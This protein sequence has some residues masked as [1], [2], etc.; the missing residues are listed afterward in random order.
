MNTSFWKK[1]S[2]KNKK[3]VDVKIVIWL[4]CKM[5]TESTDTPTYTPWRYCICMFFCEMKK[6]N[7][8]ITLTCT[9][10]WYKNWKS[11]DSN[12][13][14]IIYH[15]LKSVLGIYYF[16]FRKVDI[17]WYMY[18]FSYLFELFVFTGSIWRQK[19]RNRYFFIQSKSAKK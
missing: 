18:I 15:F 4:T 10:Y 13:S 14:P 7:V 8:T 16:F 3:S 9:I 17:T 6:P 19:W 1:K 2:L 5:I 12:L 11:Y